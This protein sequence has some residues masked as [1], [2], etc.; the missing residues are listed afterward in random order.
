MIRPEPG[1][2]F[3]QIDELNARDFNASAGTPLAEAAAR[4]VESLDE[5]VSMVEGLSD[6]ELNDLGRYT[7]LEGDV[8]LWWPV[9]GNTFAHYSEHVEIL[10][11]PETARPAGQARAPHARPKG[12]PC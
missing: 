11:Q 1:F 7:W 3:E 8:S 5:V 4:F 6:A 10:V 2:T 9:G 12:G